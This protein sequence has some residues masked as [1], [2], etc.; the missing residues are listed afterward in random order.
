LGPL[1][2]RKHPSAPAVRGVFRLRGRRWPLRLA[3]HYVSR[4]LAGDGPVQER[5]ELSQY[6]L[7]QQVELWLAAVKADIETPDLWAELQRDAELFQAATDE[8]IENTPFTSAEQEE[9]AGQLRELRDHVSRAHSPSESQMRLLDER[10]DYLAAAAGRVGR[11]DWLFM[12]AGVM[13]SYALEAAL[14]PEAARDILGTLLTSIGH[15]LGRG[16]LGLP[17]G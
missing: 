9:I 11:K 17:G 6:R 3:G 16:P 8:A 5:T 15:I 10:L 7:M 13:L 14:P 2:R 1:S 12:V 4:Y